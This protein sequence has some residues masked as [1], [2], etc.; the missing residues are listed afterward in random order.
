MIN[1]DYLA[2]ISYGVN[3]PPLFIL[4]RASFNYVTFRSTNRSFHWY[5]F[6]TRSP[7]PEINPFG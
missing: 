7:Y 3:N 2:A 1:D 6:M 5:V 4:A